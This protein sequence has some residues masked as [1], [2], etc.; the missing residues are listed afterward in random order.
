MNNA[1]K[2]AFELVHSDIYLQQKTYNNVMAL[3]QKHRM[4][5]RKPTR[6][7]VAV[8]CMVLFLLTGLGGYDV[9]YTEAAAISIDLN[10]S[11]ELSINCFGRIVQAKAFDEKSSQL[12]EELSLTHL[13]YQE[14][15][16]KFLSN[17]DMEQY[18]TTGTVVS[19]TLETEKQ[20]EERWLTNL[21]NCVTKVLNDHHSDVTAEY[22]CT[23]SSVRQ[24]AHHQGMTMGKYSAIQ[25]IMEEESE[26]TLEEFRDMD[27]D[28]IKSHKDSCGHGGSSNNTQENKRNGHH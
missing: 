2:D 28:E 9:Y 19:V 7:A 22:G 8:V 25:D 18:L 24:E 23:T 26:A 16:E 12:L 14:A 4:M 13:T 6:W 27:I 10:P 17:P 21:E 1:I 20:D 15:L 5:Y 11:I 3:A